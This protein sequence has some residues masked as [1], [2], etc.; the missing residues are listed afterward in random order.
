MAARNAWAADQR[1]GNAAD[2]G[3]GR[4]EDYGTSAGSNRRPSCSPLA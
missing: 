2:H 3:A 4:A 1:S